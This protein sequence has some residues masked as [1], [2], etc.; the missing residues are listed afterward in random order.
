CL[1]GD[2]ADAPAFAQALRDVLQQE[3]IVIAAPVRDA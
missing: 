1:H 3:G 2:R